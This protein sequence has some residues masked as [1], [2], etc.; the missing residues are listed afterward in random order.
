[1][2]GFSQM[3]GQKKCSHLFSVPGLEPAID[4][5]FSFPYRHR[6]CPRFQLLFFTPDYRVLKNKYI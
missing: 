6:A 4:S 1:M 2:I 3:R 5:W